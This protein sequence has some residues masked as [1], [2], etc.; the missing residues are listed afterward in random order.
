MDEQAF[1]QRLCE[2]SLEDGKIYI[3]DHIAELE[4]HARIGNLIKDEAQRQEQRAIFV[5]LKL[6]E[7]LIFFGE[8]VHHPSSHALGL[9]AKGSALRAMGYYQTAIEYLDAAGEEFL[10]LGDE[11][12]WARSRLSWIISVAWLG[13]VQDALQEAT[14]A[15]DIFIKYGEYYWSSGVDQNVAVIYLQIGEYQQALAIYERIL[16]AYAL[17]KDKSETFIQRAVAMIRVNQARNLALLGNFEQAYDLEHQALDSFI[18]LEDTIQI[19]N[20][21]VNLAQ[22]D[23]A[24]GHYGSALQRY[25]QARDNLVHNNVAEPFLLAD[26]DIHMAKCLVKLNRVHEACALADKAVKA[27]R[28]VEASLDTGDALCEYAATLSNS[29]RL[30]EAITALDE[31]EIIFTKGSFGHYVAITKLQRAELLL[32]MGSIAEAYTL[33]HNVK[34]FFDARKFVSCSVRINLV[35]VGTLI[36]NARQSGMRQE[37]EQQTLLLQQATTWC[38]QATSLAH[39]HNLQEQVYKGQ[40]L[41]GQLA[42]LQGNV[43]RAIG[44][45][46]AAIDQIE[47]ILNN[48]VHDLSPSFLRTT[49][50]V[51]EDM[52]ALYLQQGQIEDA[53]NFLERARSVVLRR[54]INKLREPAH[55]NETIKEDYQVSR[56]M[57]LKIATTLRLQ[58][59]MEKWQQDYRKYS[60]L[61][62]TY[63]ENMLPSFNQEQIKSEFNRCEEKLGELFE[64]QYLQEIDNSTLQIESHF[65]KTH[66]SVI[67]AYYVDISQV[68]QKLTADQYLLSYFL[69][70]EK[71]I[72][73]AASAEYLKVYECPDGAEQIEHLLLLLHAH[74]QPGSWHDVHHPPQKVVQRLLNKLYNILI[75]PVASLLPSSGYLTIIPYGMLHNL[76]FHALHDGKNFLVEKFQINY[77][78]ATSLA[79]R[80]PSSLNALSLEE[81]RSNTAPLVFGYSGHNHLQ[82]VIEE[83]KTVAELLK[84]SCYLEEK[85]TITHLIEQAPGCSIIHLAAHGQSRLD[86]PNFSSMLLADGQFTALDAFSLSLK[87]CEL[88]TLSGCETGLSLIGG[89]DE[90][91]GLGRAFLS[92]GAASLVMSLWSVEDNA[93]RELMQIFY[94]RLLEGATKVEALQAAQCSLLHNKSSR[95]MHPYFWAGF[96]LIGDVGPLR[97][98]LMP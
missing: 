10:L 19:T 17:L 92:A 23:Y 62:A 85:A 51:Y 15:R 36:E 52:I 21:E 69:Y 40:H 73:F 24:I 70:R 28:Q 61:L 90:Q 32:E 1:L 59:E 16:A 88:V 95:Y 56:S 75:E 49:W 48:L 89:G 35:I 18:L 84:G 53:F 22:F 94:Q 34:E 97:F 3:W 43:P 2:L 86:A 5:A 83:A 72:I 80:F 57:S 50:N 58:Q 68:R 4:D 26:L 31:A 6:A 78:P 96:R 76:P 33:A 11:V 66:H 55:S 91:L 27:Y 45:Y 8:Y 20:T 65:R 29:G 30:K 44:H 81:S 54:Y 60:M 7:L 79:N 63:D 87:K 74:L 47:R 25:Y 42:L 82:H 39:Q 13:R 98:K 46:R 9:I 77:L 71:L 14:R 38:R 37:Y 93:T 64:R 12:G 41:L 67:P